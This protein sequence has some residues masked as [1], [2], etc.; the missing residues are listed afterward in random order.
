M[1]CERARG[2]STPS[3]AAAGSEAL[4][5]NDLTKSEER[6][7]LKHRGRTLALS[8]GIAKIWSTQS[9]SIEVGTTLLTKQG[10]VTHIVHYLDTAEFLQFVS[11]N[12]PKHK[13]DVTP[14]CFVRRVYGLLNDQMQQLFQD[15]FG[16][17]TC[18]KIQ[19]LDRIQMNRRDVDGED[20]DDVDRGMGG[21]D[22]FDGEAQRKM[23]RQIVEYFKS[24]NGRVSMK[25]RNI[26]SLVEMVE[27]HEAVD[28]GSDHLN[29]FNV[30]D[31]AI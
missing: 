24:G 10:A 9:K 1:C 15:H 8:R 17:G 5:G 16:V 29:S 12:Q 28:S 3:T 20:K 11:D 18:F 14:Y 22:V 25:R 7:I 19:F 2:T 6:L 26:M 23:E 21:G 13:H 31:A 30:E 27:S 4:G